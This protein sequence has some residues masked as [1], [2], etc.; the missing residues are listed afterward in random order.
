MTQLSQLMKDALIDAGAS[1]EGARVPATYL[2]SDA[3]P[4]LE[5]ASLIGPDRGLTRRGVIA[6]DRAVAEA[7]DKA[8]G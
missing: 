1:R 2:K 4:D 7:L 3:I 6:R 5:N 8:F